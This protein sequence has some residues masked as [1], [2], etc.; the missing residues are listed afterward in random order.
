MK[1]LNMLD[2]ASHSVKKKKKEC[3]QNEITM[4]FHSPVAFAKQGHSKFIR[5][6]QSEKEQEMKCMMQRFSLTRSPSPLDSLIIFKLK[7]ST[8]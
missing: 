6:I 5:L 2:I 1:I 3:L 4:T 7:K 8:W